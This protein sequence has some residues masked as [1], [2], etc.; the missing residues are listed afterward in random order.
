MSEIEIGNLLYLGLLAAV[1]LVW[2]VVHN[3][4]SLGRK[5][6]HAAVWGLIF[7]GTIATVG[8]WSDIRRAAI[9]G[10][11]VVASEGRI[12]LPRAPDGHYYV[13]LEINGTPVRFVVDTGATGVVLT[14]QD[15]RR[16]GLGAEDIIFR[17][18]ASTANGAVRTAPV[19]LDSVALG[20]FEDRNVRAYV[21]EGEMTTSLLGMTYLS[22]FGRLEIANGRMILER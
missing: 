21:N 9:P 4:E 13:R 6:Q 16:A 18:S 12:E 11:A 3:R 1:L 20:P 2:L 22:R 7:L 15:A 19:R 10:Q 17:S 14:R 5:L 8:L